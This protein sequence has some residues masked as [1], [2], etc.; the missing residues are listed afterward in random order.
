MPRGA[1]NANRDVPLILTAGWLSPWATIR[2]PFTP[3]LEGDQRISGRKPVRFDWKSQASSA[4]VGPLFSVVGASVGR[5]GMDPRA[6]ALRA[7]GIS[8]GFALPFAYDSNA[9][10]II[11]LG[12]INGKVL[13]LDAYPD[14]YNDY[15]CDFVG[16]GSTTIFDTG[17]E[18]PIL[19]SSTYLQ[20]FK[21]TVDGATKLPTIDYVISKSADEDIGTTITISFTSAPAN[22]AAIRIASGPA[23]MGTARKTFTPSALYQIQNV[24]GFSR[25][26]FATASVTWGSENY[27]ILSVSEDLKPY[28]RLVITVDGDEIEE[29]AING[30]TAYWDE[31]SPL[32]HA[33]NDGSE[34]S[35]SYRPNFLVLQLHGDAKSA[36]FEK[37]VTA[38][39]VPAAG[40][41]IE[42][43]HLS[44][45]DL[46]ILGECAPTT[47]EDGHKVWVERSADFIWIAKSIE[48][49]AGAETVHHITMSNI[50][51]TT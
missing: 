33:F 28:G 44:A 36:A 25:L 46:L 32:G 24:G 11:R 19:F 3:S 23:I 31:V 17:D 4:L 2:G 8:S 47:S 10:T 22:L 50:N 16:D 29:D 15:V 18:T 45:A 1:G 6:A 27:K 42:I 21:V 12:G 20:S 48:S 51:R 41:D 26:S 34:P 30:Y 5:V 40:V 13:P 9:Y 14:G 35:G 38:T 43:F 7:D 39:F 49:S 37:P